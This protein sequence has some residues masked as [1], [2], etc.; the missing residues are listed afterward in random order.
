MVSELCK[1]AHWLD[2]PVEV[3]HWRTHDG[4]EVDL[5]MERG[6]GSVIAYEVKAA[7]DVRPEDTRGLRAL[8]RRL[9]SDQVTGVVLHTGRHGWRID[10]RL[11]ALPIAHL[12][13][14]E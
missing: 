1:Q 6:D 3:G 13:E 2:D 14:A 7:A 10:A 11:F 4:D 8:A 12:W 9:G 5:V